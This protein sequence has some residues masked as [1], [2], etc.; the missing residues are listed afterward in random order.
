[1]TGLLYQLSNFLQDT[2][3][4]SKKKTLQ[5]TAENKIEKLIPIYLSLEPDVLCHH[6]ER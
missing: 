2:L 6:S 5:S 3:G 1:M 4:Q